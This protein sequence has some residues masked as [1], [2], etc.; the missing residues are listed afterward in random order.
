MTGSVLS[1]MSRFSHPF[2]IRF[3]RF[4]VLHFA[5]YAIS[6]AATVVVSLLVVV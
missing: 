5:V 2:F 3:T 1:P 6:V 4:S